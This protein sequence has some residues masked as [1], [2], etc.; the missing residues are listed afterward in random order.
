[1]VIGVIH[2]KTAYYENT[3]T[4]FNHFCIFFTV[5][6][7]FPMRQIVPKRYPEHLFSPFGR[8]VQAN[9]VHCINPSYNLKRYLRIDG[10]VVCNH[11]TISADHIEIR[12]GGVLLN[13][14][15]SFCKTKSIMLPSGKLSIRG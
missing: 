11:G 4:C 3:T 2:Y 14:G 9:E 1:M 7:P 10:G 12:N 15:R 5:F 8:I 13:Y 6:G